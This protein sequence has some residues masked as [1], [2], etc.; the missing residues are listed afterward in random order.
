[1]P[2]AAAVGA[3]LG[4]ALVLRGGSAVIWSKHQDAFPYIKGM[5]VVFLS[6][7]VSPICSGALPLEKAVC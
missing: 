3:T 5:L 7:V 4:M 6:W 2:P 1:L